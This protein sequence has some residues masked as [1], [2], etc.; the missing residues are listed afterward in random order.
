[1][2][3][4]VSVAKSLASKKRQK[5]DANQE[6]VA[7]GAANLGAAFTGGYPVTGGIS[8]SVV[9]YTAGAN[10]GLA[11]IITAVIIAITV[12]FFTPI[13]YFLPNAVL[14]AIII[15]AVA[16]MVDVKTFRHV[17]AYSKTD[18][19]AML[20]TFVAVLAVGVEQGI[21]LGVL[22]SLFI[23]A[24]R[25]SRP[26]V[27]IVGRVDDT[28]IYRNVVRHDVQT[29]PTAVA[30]RVDES[31]Y[32]ANATYLEELVVQLLADQPEMQHFVFIGTAI[33]FIDASALE[34]LD[35]MH[36]AL[37][38]AGVT[39]HLAAMKGPVMDRLSASGLIDDIGRENVHLSTHEAMQAI[40]LVPA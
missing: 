20:I 23:L 30:M 31:L 16:G 24:W 1:Y 8:R 25:I 17:W 9:N 14:A 39:L 38:D 7:L 35:A 34:S 33:N 32:F 40:G 18:G 4:S 26:H 6:L 11:A 2:M 21:L 22:A 28:E 19:L 12:L 29:W 27:A 37:K 13:F 5:I 15:V 3:E 36:H 10:T